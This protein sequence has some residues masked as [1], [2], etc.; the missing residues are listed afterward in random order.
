[1]PDWL[2]H[3]VIGLVLIELIPLKKK[4]QK[5]LILLGTILPD[6]L[7]KFLMVEK[8]I[9][10]SE[11]FSVLTAFHSPFILFLFILLIAPLFRISYRSVVLALSLGTASHILSDFMLHHLDP[12]SGIMLFYPFSFVRFSLGWV[13]PEQPYFI[14]IPL[15]LVYLGLILIKKY[16]KERVLWFKTS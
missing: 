10:L 8:W 1:M 6:L 2:T 11:G 16:L 9:P 14:L 13:W 7:T 3:L 15:L 5:S 4:G 12:G